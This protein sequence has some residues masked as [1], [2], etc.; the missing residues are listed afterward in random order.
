MHLLFQIFSRLRHSRVQGALHCIWLL[1]VRSSGALAL[2]PMPALSWAEHNNKI[3]RKLLSTIHSEKISCRGS[4]HG[5]LLLFH[6]PLPL[7]HLQ[8]GMILIQEMGEWNM[9]PVYSIF[10]F[11][12]GPVSLEGLVPWVRPTQKLKAPVFTFPPPV[13][14]IVP[15][16]TFV[17]FIYILSLY[18]KYIG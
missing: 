17:H 2:A 16:A 15:G 13:P 11:Y 12:T 8:A 9:M 5:L 3:S 7:S 14:H 1:H 4:A 6:I 18:F 10:F